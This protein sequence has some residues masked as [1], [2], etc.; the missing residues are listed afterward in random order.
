MLTARALHHAH[1][2]RQVLNGVDIGLA[3]GEVLGLGG[4]SGS[5][6]TTLCRILA[7]QLVPDRG[8][9]LLDG[10]KLKSARPGL[11]APVQYAPQSPELAV[12]PRWTVRRILA[13]GTSPDPEVLEALGIRDDWSDRRAMQLSG[14]QLARVSLA[15]LFHPGLQ[16][17]ICDEIT[18]QLDAIEQDLLLRALM[19]LAGRRKLALLL[20][21]HSNA[22]RSRF[23]G[24]SLELDRQGR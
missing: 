9:V 17:L 21:S 3:R 16:A 4:A 24:G 1:G 22:L 8:E 18:S 10:E 19:D 15:R 2:S 20:V 7:G 5:G 13:N 6:K 12:D 11:P 23:C 14:G